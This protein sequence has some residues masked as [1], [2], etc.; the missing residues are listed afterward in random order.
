MFKE[1]FS[2]EIGTALTRPM[3]YIFTFLMALG[4]ALMVIFGESIGGS[5]NVY[6]N[7][8]HAITRL[9]G[10]LSLVALLISTAFFNNA[11]LR[12]YK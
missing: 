4:S 2:K 11:A 5:S 3:I 1:F 7:A 8:P 12:D 10:S 6:L 9:V